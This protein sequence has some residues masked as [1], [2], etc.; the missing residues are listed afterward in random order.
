MGGGSWKDVCIG[1]P[2]LAEG[3]VIS[4]KALSWYVYTRRLL[5]WWLVSEGLSLVLSRQPTELQSRMNEIASVMPAD[6]SFEALVDLTCTKLN[7][8]KRTLNSLSQKLK[9]AD[10]L[11][12]F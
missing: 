6:A 12:L 1:V 2:G 3:G 9:Q 4:M 8:N 11:L 7:I 10:R 5:L